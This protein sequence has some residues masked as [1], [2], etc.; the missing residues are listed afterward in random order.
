MLKLKDKQ[1]DAFKQMD[2]KLNLRFRKKGLGEP[3]RN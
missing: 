2:C 1:A 3:N